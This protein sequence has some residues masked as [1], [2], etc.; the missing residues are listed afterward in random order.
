MYPGAEE[1]PNGI[2]D[3]YDALVDESAVPTRYYSDADGDGYGTDPAILSIA[4]PPG[5]ISQS[6]DCDDTPGAGALT[7]PGAPER[8]DAKDNDCDG[9]FDE[10]LPLVTF[11]DDDQDGFGDEKVK[12]CNDLRQLRCKC[13][14][15]LR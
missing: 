9:S 1:V 12:V 7:Y 14:W 5:Y 13:D 3:D 15:L 10:N 4:P 2:D 8:C 11:A 6:G